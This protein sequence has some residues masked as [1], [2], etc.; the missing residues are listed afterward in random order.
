MLIAENI[1]GFN[2]LKANADMFKAFLKNFYNSWGL[3]AR[4]TI[5]PIAVKFEKNKYDGAY[6]RFDYEI[7]GRK[8]WLH[9]KSV[10]RWY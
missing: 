8:E 9:V 4:E 1:K 7:Y 2:K 6:L 5:R 10:T 3:E